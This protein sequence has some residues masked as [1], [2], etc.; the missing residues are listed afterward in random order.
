MSHFKEMIKRAAKPHSPMPIIL[1]FTLSEGFKKNREWF[2]ITCHTCNVYIAVETEAY[3]VDIQT[4][5]GT[6]ELLICWVCF[7]LHII[8]YASV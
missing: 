7:S 1:Y 5:N 4:R 3:G 6:E 2:I 8:L